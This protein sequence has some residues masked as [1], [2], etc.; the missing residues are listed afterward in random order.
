MRGVTM[1][2]NIHSLNLDCKLLGSHFSQLHQR[3][4]LVLSGSTDKDK[5][6]RAAVKKFSPDFGKNSPPK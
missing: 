1:L 5:I 2:Q 6:F 3:A 4:V